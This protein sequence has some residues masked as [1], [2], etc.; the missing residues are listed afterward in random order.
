MQS[1][2]GAERKYAA[3]DGT[4]PHERAPGKAAYS[5]PCAPWRSGTRKASLTSSAPRSLI[6]KP[7]NKWTVVRPSMAQALGGRARAWRANR[8]GRGG[9][10]RSDRR[11]TDLSRPDGTLRSLHHK[12]QEGR[13]AE[14]DEVWRRHQ[15]RSIW[16]SLH[17]LS[18]PRSHAAF[19]GTRLRTQ[20][21]GAFTF[22]TFR[23]PSQ[24][25]PCRSTRQW[26]YQSSA[27]EVCDPHLCPHHH[28]VD[29]HETGAPDESPVLGFFAVGEAADL[30]LRLA[31]ADVVAHGAECIL[32]SGG[33]G[34]ISLRNRDRTNRNWATIE[35]CPVQRP[36]SPPRPR[37]P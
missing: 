20:R 30:R 11:A 13:R 8:I 16:Q 33:R 14:S 37:K 15:R 2:A 3:Q 28:A 24:E 4:G 19:R 1:A 25:L 9:V 27:R 32:P 36:Q 21:A 18:D 23:M 29:S 17:N 7:R 5:K 26:R 34:A 12:R 35:V 31:E 10:K 6:A 22:S